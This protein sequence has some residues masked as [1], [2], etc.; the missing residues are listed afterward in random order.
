MIRAR[1]IDVSHWDGLVNYPKMLANGASFL[2]AKASQWAA[3]PRFAENW[4]NAKGILPRGAYH[5]LDWGWSEIKQAELFVK[6]MDGDWG[7]LPPVLDLEMNPAPYSLTAALISNKAWNFL[8]HVE[9]TT[10]RIP[11]LYTG[12]YF[13]N[14]WGSNDIGWTHFPLWLA[15]Y[16]P[17]WWVRV[18]KPWTKWTLW[19]DTDRADGLKFGCQSKGVDANWFNG[20]VAEM[21]AWLKIGQEAPIKPPIPVRDRKCP[22]VQCPVDGR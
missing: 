17:E 12:Y 22:F 15:W 6:T 4:K 2:Y 7:E 3:D 21:R 10:G 19:Q 18:P 20:T 16:A 14:S 5:F 11:M 13:W 8:K 9:N 1:G